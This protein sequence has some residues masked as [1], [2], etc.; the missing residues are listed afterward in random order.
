MHN[1]IIYI[2]KIKTYITNGNGNTLKIH[3]THT[4]TS[5][6]W[7]EDEIIPRRD[8]R[9][10]ILVGINIFKKCRCSPSRTQDY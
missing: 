8:D 10:V 2:A 5:Q 4:R 9:Y 3:S 7:R 1:K 6:H